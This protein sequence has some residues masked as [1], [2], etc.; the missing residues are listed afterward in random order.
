[1]DSSNKKKYDLLGM[2]FGTA[3]HQLRKAI[4][5]CLIQKT[6]E[7]VCY[8]CGKKIE[9]IDD[10]SIEH[11]ISWQLSQNPRREFFDLNNI[12]F[13][14][15][16]CN[17]AAGNRTVSRPNAKGEKNPRVKLTEKQVKEIKEKIKLGFG[18]RGLSKEYSV[19]RYCIWYIRKELSWK[20]I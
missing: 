11:K 4:M 20:D 17:M 6:N 8:R 13:S 18:D 14:H 2:P 3:T 16:N 5:F 10:L 15:L 12:A 1:M 7:D 9:S 19:S